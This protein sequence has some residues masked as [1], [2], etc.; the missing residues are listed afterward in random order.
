M[1][2]FRKKIANLRRKYRDY[3]WDAE[4]RDVLGAEIQVDGACRYSVFVAESC[5]HA[6]VVVNP[7]LDRTVS[8]E[9]K[10]PSPGA[11]SVA[12]PE[13][14]DARPLSGA[15]TVPPR[16]AAVVFER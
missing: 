3:L 2:Y 12:T 10:L 5:K 13:E 11:L 15:L 7:S 1:L 14:P 6:V 9:V 16:S 4:Y 8:A